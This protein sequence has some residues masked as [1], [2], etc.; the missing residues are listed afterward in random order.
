METL[1]TK[2]RKVAE[3][4]HTGQADKAGR[5]YITHPQ[6]VAARC[7][8]HPEAVAVGWLHDVVEDTPL[9]L[10]DLRSSGFPESVVNAVDAI[11]MRPGEDRAT[12]YSRVATNPLALQVKLA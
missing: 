2:A 5:P 3:T 7:Q 10:N 6:R 11:T 8:G 1:A 4:M 9:T 12:Y